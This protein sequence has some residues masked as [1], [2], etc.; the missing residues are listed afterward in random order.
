MEEENVLADIKQ[1]G[2]KLSDVGSVE[3]LLSQT[4]E[5]ET[6]TPAESPTENNE[7]ETEPSQQGE[8]GEDAP[9]NT[10]DEKPLP[11]HEHPRWQKMQKELEEK[12]EALQALQESVTELQEKPTQQDTTLPQWWQTLAGSD[13]VSK[14]AYSQY[15]SENKGTRD[16]MRQELIEEQQQQAQEEQSE[17]KKWD[18]WVVGEIQNLKDN[19]ETFDENELRKVAVEMQPLDEN[20]NI[21]LSK[22]LEILKLQKQVKANPEAKKERKKIASQTS[23]NNQGEPQATS[24]AMG[25][26]QV[27]NK[28]WGS[29]VSD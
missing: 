4:D 22:S 5:E 2:T 27:R 12:E 21:S 29:L 25:T 9:K 8:E 10:A 19:G 23:S 26:N 15:Q 7:A 14:Q 20:G 11:F 28:S 17:S 6:E 24:K 1:E 3:E 16:A 18:D 13:E